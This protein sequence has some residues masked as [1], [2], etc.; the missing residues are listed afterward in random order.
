[1]PDESWKARKV[2][3]ERLAE[4]WNNWHLNDMRAGCEHQRANWSTTEKLEVVHYGLTLKASQMRTK[5]I[6]ETARATARGEEIKLS[7][8]ARVLVLLEDW[9]KDRFTPPDAD[10]PLS[11]CYEIR[12]REQKAAGWVREDEHPRGLLSKPCTACGYKYGSAWLK[13]DVP[14]DVLEW[15]HGLPDGSSLCPTTWLKD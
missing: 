13:E 8:T 4:V 7:D 5:A 6:E 2:D 1:M 12:K 11:G 10:S 14:E 3:L 9:F 15:L